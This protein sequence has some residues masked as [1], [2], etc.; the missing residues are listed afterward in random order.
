MG[1]T[2][3]RL[4]VETPRV[5][6][7]YTQRKDT[8]T[9]MEKFID[10][11][12]IVENDPDSCWRWQLSKNG[13][14]YGIFYPDGVRAYTHRW[15]YS[16]FVGPLEQGKEIDHLCRQPDCVRPEHLEQVT[17]R[18]NTIRG[19]NWAVQIRRH[20]ETTGLC[21]AGHEF[22]ET[23]YEGGKCATCVEEYNKSYKEEHRDRILAYGRQYDQANKER[24]G[25]Y[26]KARYRAN[27]DAMNTKQ[28]LY[29]NRDREDACLVCGRLRKQCC[30][31]VKDK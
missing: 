6:R 10:G 13:V 3:E 29:R 1:D 20:R 25:A 21:V 14:G 9:T 8:K 27:Q 5:K 15:S 22:K 19:K 16:Y 7:K 11:I 18:E 24:K 28:R 2:M 12:Q 30:V 17:H 23:T 26:Q 31:L 4:Q